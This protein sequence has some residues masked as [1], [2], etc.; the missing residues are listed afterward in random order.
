[1]AIEGDQSE[2][3]EEYEETLTSFLGLKQEEGVTRNIKSEPI[4][5]RI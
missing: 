2:S 3:D 1:M 4:R 5:M